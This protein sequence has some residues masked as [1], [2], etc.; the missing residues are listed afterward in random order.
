MAPGLTKLSQESNIP[1]YEVA[2]KLV[3]T[4]EK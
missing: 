2:R 4:R 3:Q 1:L